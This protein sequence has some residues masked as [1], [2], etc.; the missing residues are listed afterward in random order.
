MPHAQPL[1]NPIS[2]TN[3]EW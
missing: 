1:S 3:D 2:S